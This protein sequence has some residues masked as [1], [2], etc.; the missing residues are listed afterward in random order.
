MRHKPSLKDLTPQEYR[1]FVLTTALAGLLILLALLINILV[2]TDLPVH[3]V[4]LF[5]IYVA[6]ASSYIF[7]YSNFLVPSRI[8]EVALGWLNSIFSGLGFFF[9]AYLIPVEL[10]VYYGLLMIVAVIALSILSGRY[11]TTLMIVIGAL[12]MFTVRLA[13]TGSFLD[14]VKYL[15]MPAGALITSETLFRIQ[16]IARRQIQRLEM[17]N[18]F[19]R[20]V[21]STLDREEIFTL[22]KSAIPKAV[23]AD[24]YYLGVADGD[25]IDIPVFF[26][27]GAFFNGIRVQ[28]RGTL[29]GWVVE[30]QRELFLPDL[31]KPLD[32]DG[33]EVVVV[34]KDRVSLSW[35]G[36]PLISTRIKGV[37]ALASYQPNA[38]NR[39]DMELLANLS[40][41]T[42]LALENAASHAEVEARARL[43]SMTGVL[44]HGYFLKILQAYASQALENGT[45]LSI[46]ML[47][48][49]FFKQYNDTYGHLV[50]DTILNLLC[51]TMRAHIKST[52][53]IGRWGGEEFIIALP[54]ADGRQASLVAGRIRKT[55]SQL[56]IPGRDGGA[57]PAPT[58]SQGLAVFPHER[59]DIYKLIDL[60]DQRLYVA[61][62]RGRD[63][64]EPH[65]DFWLSPPTPS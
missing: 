1:K 65:P 60:A 63:Q 25:E 46:I 30:H 42:A 48:I 64:I 61:K 43:D 47:D 41:H 21:A 40:Q 8:N 15:S 9:M 4:E 14:W 19:S 10:L 12:P 45:P 36:V 62:E 56:N 24:S 32:L 55:M 58:V 6:V 35:I 49:D 59:G 57:I 17:I 31:R 7:M 27:D 26:D 22:V 54:N 28:A 38:F 29:S 23:E 18:A 51:D 5:V 20:Q 2:E 50:G 13:A 34:G 33:V 3:K 44:N 39:G 52:D 11:P 37:M 53:S 16:N